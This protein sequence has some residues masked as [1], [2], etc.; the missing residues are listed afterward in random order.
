[1]TFK[2]GEAA[3]K[4]A[5]A[6]VKGGMKVAK[7]GMKVAKS[8]MN[9][10]AKGAKFI[11][12]KGKV[13]F[14]GIAGTALGKGFKRLKELGVALLERTRFKRF[15]VKR[16]GKFFQLWAQI[17]PDILLANV[18]FKD[19]A[20]GKATLEQHLKHINNAGKSIDDIER[21]HLTKLAQDFGQ[22]VKSGNVIDVTKQEI[23][24]TLKSVQPQNIGSNP[25]LG[26]AWQRS[27]TKVTNRPSWKTHLNPDGTIKPSSL[28][29]PKVMKDLYTDVRFQLNKELENVMGE[30]NTKM[31]PMTNQANSLPTGVE[32]HHLE[33]KSVYP[34]GAID[35][36]NLVLALRKSKGN[37]DEL[38]DLLHLLGSGSEGNRFRKFL[39]EMGDIIKEY[40]KGV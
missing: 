24:D 4:G 29:N 38:H 15:Y 22:E 36:N 37:P 16:S 31:G 7:D 28:S 10:I 14:K 2:A 8:A 3:F 23:K 17:N 19:D 21:Q 35:S 1:M 25:V 11:I 20:I 33:P 12:E 18:P 30:I 27:I 6:A 34:E 13:L 40:K 9:L 5:K 26:E 39:P 32:V